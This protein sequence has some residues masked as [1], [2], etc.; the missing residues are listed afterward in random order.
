MNL[1]G[2]AAEESQQRR[3]PKIAVMLMLVI[4]VCMAMLAAFANV[5]RIRRGVEVILVRPAGSPI[6]PAEKR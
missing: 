3:V 4:V 5:Q 1:P 6:P 2:T